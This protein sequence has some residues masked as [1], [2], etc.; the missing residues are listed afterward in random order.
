MH[1]FSERLSK[2]LAIAVEAHD[3]QKRTGTDIP[4][5]V[6]PI[7]VC[8][9]VIA[10]GGNERQA[11]A[12]LLHD[13]IED[14]GARYAERIRSEIGED[15]LALV[16]ACT[17]VVPD[18]TGRK[19]PWKDRKL[20]H[21]ARMADREQTTDE[22]ILVLSADKFYNL[23]AIFNDAVRIG[24]E[25]YKRFTARKEGTLWYYGR[26]VEVLSERRSPLAGELA[27]LLG[28]VESLPA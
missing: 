25:V 2:S 10:H 22:A 4:Y 5:I 14:G 23:T 16:M 18:A 21:L 11:C 8:E 28:K 12:A 27:E 9:I 13:T 19:G 24:D 7:G 17:D 26:L 6:H 1:H 20:R 3:R 15:V